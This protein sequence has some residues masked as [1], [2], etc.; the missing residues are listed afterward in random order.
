[1]E[2]GVV[3]GDMMNRE[4]RGGFTL[5]ELLVVIAIIGVLASMLLVV[6][7]S[8]KRKA[9]AIHCFNNL[10]QMG[11]ATF[12]Y[13]DKNDDRLPFAWYDNPE[14]QDNNFYSLLTPLVYNS[15][16]DGFRDFEENIFACPTRKREPLP[17]NNPFKISYG[18]N[19]YNSVNF[20]DPQTRKLSQAQ[21][22]GAATILIADELFSY[23]HP[24]LKALDLVGYKH[25]GHA[26]FV[27]Y[28]GHVASLTPKQTNDLVLQF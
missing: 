28:D 1:L 21:A 6:L 18:M 2:V 22:N 24:P 4:R 26:N 20:P 9:Q 13:C 16:F 15:E 11:L 19:A 10:R 12:M 25:R 3:S 27:F 14:P 7:G 23:N 17:T 5:I 8:A